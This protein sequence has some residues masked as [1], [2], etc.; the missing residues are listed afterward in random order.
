[1][2]AKTFDVKTAREHFPAITNGKQIYCDNAGGSQILGDVVDAIKQYLTVSNVQ[3]GASYDVSRNSTELYTKGYEAAAKYVNADPDEIVIGSSTTQVFRNLSFALSFPAGSELVI[4]KLDHETNIDAWTDLAARQNLKV[5]WWFPTSEDASTNPILS[6]EN[7]LPL[8]SD[9]TVFVSCTHASNILGTIH[10]IKEL[11]DTIHKTCPDA[12]F[13]VDAVAYAPHRQLDV[14]ATEVDFYAFSW[15]KVYGPHIAQLYAKR[16]VQKKLLTM[17]HYFNPQDT[18]E[19]KIG[20]AGSC[21]ELTQTIPTIVSYLGG[22]D[23]LEKTFA[24]IS[25]HEEILAEI[26]LDFLRGRKDVVILGQKTSDRNLRVPTISF[27]VKEKSAKAIVEEVEKRSRFG[28]RW[29]SFYSK[30]LVDEVLQLGNEGVV[31]VSLVHYNTEEEVKE[32]VEVLKGIL[33]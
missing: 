21:Y 16:S 17:G 12:L 7:L 28:I 10:L 27:N 31:R 23:G 33:G 15:Y 25:A 4:S 32:L 9:K 2:A 20:V 3:L 14:K 11:A 30:R 24:E 26:L 5:K 8:L 13:C 6:P 1:M 29:G 22:A 18:L 19:R